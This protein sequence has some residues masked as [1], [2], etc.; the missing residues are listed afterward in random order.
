MFDYHVLLITISGVKRQLTWR[1]MEIHPK[2]KIFLA[3]NDYLQVVTLGECVCLKALPHI[4]GDS[5]LSF[6]WSRDGGSCNE[7]RLEKV[8]TEHCTGYYTC[9]ISKSE[10]HL[11][12]V[13][14]CLKTIGELPFAIIL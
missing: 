8:T 3:T 6:E 11:F 10:E 5:G 1:M 9:E 7:L 2:Y 14:H 12:R 13:H 4:K